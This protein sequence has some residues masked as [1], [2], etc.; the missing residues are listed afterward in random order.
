MKTAFYSHPDFLLHRS[1]SAHPERPLHPE[2]PARLEALERHLRASGQWEHLAHAA[3]KPASQDDLALCHSSAMIERVRFASAASANLDPDTYTNQHSWN[4]ALLG[5]GA[6]LQAA[7]DVANGEIKQAFVASRPPGHHATPERSMGFCLFNNIALAAKQARK[8]L[9]RV[10]ILDWDVHHGNGTQDIF[11]A[12]PSVFFASLH[13][14]P[15]YPGT[16]AASERGVGAGEGSTRNIP[17][18]AGCGNA[19]YLRAWRSLEADLEA[20]E[21][22][23][24]LISAGFDAHADDPLGGMEVTEGGFAAMAREAKNWAN[25]W[26]EGRLLL[27]LE[28]GYDVEALGHSVVQVLEEL[29]R[30]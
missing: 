14:A 5:A 20:F 10:A 29:E 7:R 28:G 3:F 4:V 24:I 13:Q 19:A 12:D 1:A 16:G 8:Y 21:P 2:R 15:F 30:D 23:M 18:P 27:V 17:L 11:Y 6:A 26:C 9:E 25:R 22:Q